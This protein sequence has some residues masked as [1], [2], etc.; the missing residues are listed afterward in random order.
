MWY[1]HLT[2]YHITILLYCLLSVKASV[3]ETSRYKYDIPM[4]RY[5]R[6]SPADLFDE[7]CPLMALV[8]DGLNHSAVII[9][10]GDLAGMKSQ[11]DE[12]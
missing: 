10:I 1:Y 11:T 7:K 9:I 2:P 4:C 3:D 8:L 5:E 12:A 6:H